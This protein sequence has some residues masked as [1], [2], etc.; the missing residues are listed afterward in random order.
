MCLI[1]VTG[2]M[3]IPKLDRNIPKSFY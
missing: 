3:E 2:N 1:D